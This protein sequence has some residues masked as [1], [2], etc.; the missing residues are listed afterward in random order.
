MGSSQVAIGSNDPSNDL[1]KSSNDALCVLLKLLSV[2]FRYGYTLIGKSYRF[3]FSLFVRWKIND[4]VEWLV[5]EVGVASI[6]LKFI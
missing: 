5:F 3:K 6:F 4:G 2:T 1:S